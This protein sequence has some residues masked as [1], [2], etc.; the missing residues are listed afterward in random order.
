[1]SACPPNNS[2][3]HTKRTPAELKEKH[4]SMTAEKCFNAPLPTTDRRDGGKKI[5]K[6]LD[7]LNNTVY[8]GDIADMYQTLCP[9][10]KNACFF[11]SSQGLLPKTGNI[12]SHTAGKPGAEEPVSVRARFLT[13]VAAVCSLSRV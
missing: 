11:L 7:G 9:T 8:H 10:K 5:N 4:N 6:N 12:L 3:K 2:L 1:M 13:T